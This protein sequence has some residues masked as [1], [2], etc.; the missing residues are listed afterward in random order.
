MPLVVTSRGY[1]DR[2]PGFS[3]TENEQAWRA[4]Q[5]MQSELAALSSNSF[6]VIAE[7]SNHF[8]QFQQ[9]QLVIK[10][11]QDVV[12]HA[13]QRSSFL[14]ENSKLAPPDPP[15]DRSLFRENVGRLP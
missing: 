13:R 2:L 1:W 7:E 3:K 12:A 6:Q 10:A 15:G 4:W 5:Q 9:P 8:I 11:I 14:S